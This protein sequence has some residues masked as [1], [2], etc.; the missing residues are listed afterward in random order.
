MAK[1]NKT[2]S[3]IPEIKEIIRD[4]HKIKQEITNSM[5][6]MINGKPKDY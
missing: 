4:E 2:K 3:K 6:M 1:K 5:F